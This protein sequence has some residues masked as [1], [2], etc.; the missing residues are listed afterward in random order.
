MR[1]TQN[2]LFFHLSEDNEVDNV[3]FIVNTVACS[4]TQ[5]GLLKAM[6]SSP[7]G[8]ERFDVFSEVFNLLLRKV[9][10]IAMPVVFVVVRNH[11]LD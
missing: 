7:I 1:C 3:G 8:S 10:G 4:T 5:K 9:F 2:R 11:I 6:S